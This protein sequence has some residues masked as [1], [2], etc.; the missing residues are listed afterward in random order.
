MHLEVFG[1]HM[2]ILNT[3]VATRD[4]MDNRA[5]MY[6]DRPRMTMLTEL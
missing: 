2:I 4:L 1:G 3:V 5:A 6:S